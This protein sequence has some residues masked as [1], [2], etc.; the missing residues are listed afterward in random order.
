MGPNDDIRNRFR[1]SSRP[2]TPMPRPVRPVPVSRP[3][4][5]QQPAPKTPVAPK[6][7]MP[8]AGGRLGYAAASGKYAAPSVKKKAR[9][10]KK[11]H[12]IVFVA[13]FTLLLGGG[14]GYAFKNRNANGG[15]FRLGSGEK[16]PPPGDGVPN[17][18]IGS[19]TA[20]P[21]GTIRFV[22]TGDMIGHDSVNANAKNADGS[23]DYAKLMSGMKPYFEKADV[24]FCN[25]ATPAGGESFGITG[26]PVFNAPIAF[27]RGIEGVGC[28][29]INIGTNHTNDKGQALIDATVAAWDDRDG[30]LA[31]G[32][33]NRSL[34]EQNQSRTFTVKGVKFAFLSYT[35]YTNNASVTPFGINMYTDALAT[36]QVAEAKKNAD[37]VIVSMRWGTE[38]S[39]DING[40][41]DAI[42][43]T[44]TNLGADVII[45]HGPH[46]LEPVKKMKSTDGSKESTVWYSVGNFLNTQVET[47]AL[48]GGFAVMDI[49]AATKKIANTAFMPT[50]MHYEWTAAEKKSNN[51]PAR[52]NLQMVPLD[53]AADLLK[54]S[55]SG[56]NVETQTARVTGILNKY[57]PVKI[58]KSSEY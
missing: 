29:L 50:Y 30:I 9:R 52:K 20:T 2:A 13:I 38:Y 40:T 32:G 24:R 18:T 44:L 33:A 14:G 43:Q 53:Q 48:I 57:T 54:K 31:V 28:N 27:A 19:G 1:G 45:G 5:A 7:P 36:G 35:T 55:Q 58:I 51:L 42:A 12:I 11:K 15:A 3:A 49:D 47:E 6:P 17:G 41:Q 8:E 56:T 46:V 16:T 4:A 22:A 25:Q 10:F 37:I 21:A 26:Y 23:Y 34:G 39:P